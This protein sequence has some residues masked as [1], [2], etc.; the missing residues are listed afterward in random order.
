MITQKQ[1][2]IHVDYNPETGGFIWIKPTR[3]GFHVGDKAGSIDSYGYVVMSLHGEIYKAHRLAFLYMTGSFP[4]LEVD[5]INRVPGDNRW[6]NL[7]EL[8]HAENGKNRSMPKRNKSGFMGVMWN[9]KAER[10]IA[11]IGSKHL[12]SFKNKSDAAK[13]RKSAEKEFGYPNSG[14]IG[15]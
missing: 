15:S 4:K 13:A 10:W 1:L 2:K 7:R 9:T 12:G 14:S 6:S 5:H 8:S 3:R 11:R